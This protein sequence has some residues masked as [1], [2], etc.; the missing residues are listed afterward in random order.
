MQKKCSFTEAV[1]AVAAL[2]RSPLPAVKT[3]LMLANTQKLL[4]QLLVRWRRSAEYERR[5]D[6]LLMRLKSGV[7]GVS[8][9]QQCFRQAC[10]RRHF[11][12]SL[13]PSLPHTIFNPS[14]FSSLLVSLSS[15]L[16]SQSQPMAPLTFHEH[17]PAD[18]RNR[19]KSRL[20][21]FQTS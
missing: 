20:R 13:P 2:T 10:F 11:S 12:A 5:F 6:K 9:W 18:Q 17:S 19:A 4:R 16:H 1:G 8:S 3:L 14:A 21:R 15:F 7:A